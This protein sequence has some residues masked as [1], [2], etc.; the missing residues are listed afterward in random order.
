MLDC[1]VKLFREGGVR[2][3]FKGTTATLIRDVPGSIA[4]FGAYEVVKEKI[5]KL[6]GKQPSE[7][8]PLAV[9]FAGGCAGIANWVIAVP[10]DVV[11]SRYQTAPEGTYKGL[12]DV[13]KTLLKEEGPGAFFKGLGPAMIRA[14]PANAACFLGMEFSKSLLAFM[15]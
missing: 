11:K 7:L 1:G 5:G 2:S 13:A 4:W 15:D 8:S 6:Q 14:F 3:V 10:P 9:L 12:G